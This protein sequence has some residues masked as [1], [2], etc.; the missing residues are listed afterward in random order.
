MNPIKKTLSATKNFVVAHETPIAILV[1]ATVTAV[2]AKKVYGKAFE[3]ANQFITEKG[4]SD[5]FLDYIPTK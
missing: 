3:V 1:T 5:E 2:V 4:L